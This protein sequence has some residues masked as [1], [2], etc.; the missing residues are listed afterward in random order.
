[1]TLAF[2]YDHK[3]PIP[4]WHNSMVSDLPFGNI[5]AITAIL[6]RT[7]GNF[8]RGSWQVQISSSRSQKRIYKLEGDSQKWLVGGAK[9]YL[10]VVG[11]IVDA[12]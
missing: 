8:V 6:C 9:S 10:L 11:A 5:K 4:E 1:M 3:K 12:I 7:Q 2:L